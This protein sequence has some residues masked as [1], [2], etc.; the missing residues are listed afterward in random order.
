MKDLARRAF[1][2]QSA[3][4]L[5]YGCM[6]SSDYRNIRNSYRRRYSPTGS[7]NSLAGANIA[8]T[9]GHGFH[10]T[11]KFDAGANAVGLSEFDLNLRQADTLARTLASFGSYVDLYVYDSIRNGVSLE[12]R[13]ANASSYD[14]HVSMHHNSF[15][16]DLVQGGEVLV[17][18]A[19]ASGDD[20]RLAG[21]INSN[22]NLETGL[23]DRGVKSQNLTVLNGT[24]SAVATCL[25]EP[26]FMSARGYSREEIKELSQ[27]AATGIAK[28]IEAYW[29]AK[30]LNLGS[31]SLTEAGIYKSEASAVIVEKHLSGISSLQS[32]SDLR[33]QLT[34]KT[35]EILVNDLPGLYDGH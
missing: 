15:S 11:G 32:A 13:G 28:G 21:L 35:P 16:D 26:L 17:S 22:M 29:V 30:S 8:L 31:M 34:A 1:L 27:L 23:E 6:P 14:V 3:A 10:E 19:N 7:N 18:S 25:T 12:Q 5:L 9:V 20:K 33:R 4:L 24:A 2:T